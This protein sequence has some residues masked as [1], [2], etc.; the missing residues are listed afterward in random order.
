[1]PCLPRSVALAN[2]PDAA[3]EAGLFRVP[4]VIGG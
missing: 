3:R 1:V 4:Q 2:A